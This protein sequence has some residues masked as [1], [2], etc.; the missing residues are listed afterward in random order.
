[1]SDYKSECTDCGENCMFQS[2][3]LTEHGYLCKECISARTDAE[4]SWQ[5]INKESGYR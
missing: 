3:T 2:L 5:E 1:M 4:S